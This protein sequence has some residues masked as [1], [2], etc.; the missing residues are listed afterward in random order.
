VVLAGG[1]APWPRKGTTGPKKEAGIGGG[2][3]GATACGGC[4]THEPPFAEP[5]RGERANSFARLR[6]VGPA[7]TASV[8][9]APTWP[10]PRGAESNGPR[11]RTFIV[12]SALWRRDQDCS[13]IH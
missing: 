8:H 7:S 5:P 13:V 3:G 1:S 10:G 12:W 11:S 2:W 4:H 6:R 9:L